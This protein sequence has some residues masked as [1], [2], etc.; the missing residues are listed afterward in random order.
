MAKKAT[1]ANPFIGRWRIVS[2]DLWD[3][4]TIDEE[5]EAFIEFRAQ[6]SGEFHFC[7]IHGEM[8]CDFTIEET[9]RPPNGPGKATT[10]RIP[11]T[12]GAGR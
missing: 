9:N 4:E 5:Q 6:A 11:S 2:M 1:S 12:V 3:T 8:D 10:S 7:Y